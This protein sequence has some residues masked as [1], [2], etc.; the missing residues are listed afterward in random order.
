MSCDHN[1]I[2][3]AHARVHFFSHNLW[4]ACI[5]RSFYNAIQNGTEITNR[6][7]FSIKKV[8]ESFDTCM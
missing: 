1:N 3:G 7:Q 2:A 6:K 8:F 5:W 4:K